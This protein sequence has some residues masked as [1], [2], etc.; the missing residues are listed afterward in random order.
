[1]LAVVWLWLLPLCKAD[2][3]APSSLFGKRMHNER[4]S[5]HLFFDDLHSGLFRNAPNP[6][7]PTEVEREHLHP[8]TYFFG[9]HPVFLTDTTRPLSRSGLHEA[10]NLFGKVHVADL[11]DP[12]TPRYLTLAPNTRNMAQILC[13]YNNDPE[14]AKFVRHVAATENVY[15]PAFAAQLLPKS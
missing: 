2:I 9:G 14:L 1:M 4:Q 10:Y 7:A 3:A 6:Y 5:D 13:Y 15:G 11:S 12:A 8:Y